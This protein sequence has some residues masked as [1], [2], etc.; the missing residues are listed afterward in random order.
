MKIRI[1]AVFCVLGF[2]LSACYPPY[3]VPPN[4]PTPTPGPSPGPLSL[5]P[6]SLS[7]T[8]IGA[9]NALT[10]NVIQSNYPSD[11][12]T[13]STTTCSG[14]AAIVSSVPIGGGAR[15]SVMPVGAGTCSFTVTGGGTA[16][17]TLNVVVTTTTVGGS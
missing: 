3:T 7:F 13:A 8:A 15:L 16:S 14:V 1:T 2:V 17:A 9:A 6:T 12:F 5:S 4:P 10:V 11:A